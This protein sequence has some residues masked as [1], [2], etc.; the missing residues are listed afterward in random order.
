MAKGVEEQAVGLLIQPDLLHAPVESCAQVILAQPADALAEVEHAGGDAA[1][2]EHEWN[3]G[4]KG[5]G[6]VCAS[7]LG[8]VLGDAEELDL[9]P[10]MMQQVA[11][12]DDGGESG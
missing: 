5:A 7:E 3:V 6:E 9:R 11:E 10:G 2:V 8:E 1:V 12:C 4:R